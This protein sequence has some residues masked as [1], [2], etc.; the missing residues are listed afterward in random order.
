MQSVSDFEYAANGSDLT[1][2]GG[3]LGAAPPDANV[4]K[5]RAAK[6]GAE[7]GIRAGSVGCRLG[8]VSATRDL[9]PRR[10]LKFAR[11]SAK[12]FCRFRFTMREA[13]GRKISK[14]QTLG[15]SVRQLASALGLTERR[16]RQMREDGLVSELPDGSFDLSEARAA[17]AALTGGLAAREAFL[18]ET[19]ALRGEVE[20]GID[21]LVRAAASRKA[22]LAEEIGPKVGRLI[23]RL[24]ACSAL[25]P[26]GARRAFERDVVEAMCAGLVVAFLAA[27]GL[28]IADAD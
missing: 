21:R 5:P 23:G 3:F 22:S 14:K 12:I 9:R 24:R 16:V 20:T 27:A 28:E 6:F 1:A 15:V 19:E 18:D 13:M 17:Y 4:K 8:T 7:N 2:E 26:A 25:A 11:F 10:A